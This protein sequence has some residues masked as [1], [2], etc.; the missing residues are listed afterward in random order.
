MTKD[1]EI[2]LELLWYFQLILVSC[3]LHE[4]GHYFLAKYYKLDPKIKIYN[5]YICVS[6]KG[7]DYKKN[8]SILFSGI[9][10][11]LIYILYW[12]IDKPFDILNITIMIGYSIGCISDILQI[13][14]YAYGRKKNAA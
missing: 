14:Y 12:T 1:V 10:A 11:G 7:T 13:Y 4:S 8:L 2:L 6:H 5:Q 9:M 3:I